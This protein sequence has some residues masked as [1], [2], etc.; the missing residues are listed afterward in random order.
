MSDN[1]RL[2]QIDFTNVWPVFHYFPF[3][4][5]Q[6]WLDTVRMV[7]T[8]LNKAIAEGHIDVAPISSFAYGEL[9]DRLVLMP[10]LSVSATQEVKSILLF[11]KK[12]LDQLQQAT[13]ALTNASATSVNLLKVILHKYY[14]SNPN[15][16]TSQP[17]LAKML[18]HA[19]AALLIGDDALT[20][21]AELADTTIQVTD[22]ATL[23]REHTGFGMTFAVW[24]VREE[25]VR[26]SPAKVQALYE[27]FIASK[28]KGIEHLQPIV[29]RAVQQL[30][31]EPAEWE[32]YFRTLTYE[33]GPDMQQG[34]RYYF[35]LCH[36]QG[37]LSQPVELRFWPNLEETR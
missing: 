31:G 3:E 30:G 18:E 33:F 13:I 29:E 7:P 24:A 26:Q 27:A 37:L 35:E 21:A 8:G 28:A 23:W 34:L 10:N 11:H 22:L 6:G 1:I 20:A 17:D 9:A 32:A 12:P 36:E 4:A 16:V 2:G 15:Y 19:D 14:A 5:Y 25:V